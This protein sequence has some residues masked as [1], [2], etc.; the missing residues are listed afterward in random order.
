MT[1]GFFPPTVGDSFPPQ[2]ERRKSIQ[3]LNDRP[4]GYAL[5]TPRSHAL[6]LAVTVFG[7]F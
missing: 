1:L 4:R 6:P 5:P 2:L 3:P 7:V